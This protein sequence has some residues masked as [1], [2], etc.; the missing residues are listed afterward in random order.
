M[1]NKTG[2]NKSLKFDPRLKANPCGILTIIQ[3][4]D[5]Q[6]LNDDLDRTHYDW[7]KYTA[8]LIENESSS[9]VQAAAK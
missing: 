6:R 8:T 2:Y 1:E 4:G 3:L 7:K 9:F 5:L